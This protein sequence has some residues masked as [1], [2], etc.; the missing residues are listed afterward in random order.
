MTTLLTRVSLVWVPDRVNIWLRFGHP[1]VEYI[2]D[3]QRRVADF[4][5]G[6]L[7]CRIEWQAN[8]YGTTRWVLRVLQT[9]DAGE[10]VQVVTGVQP[11]ALVLLRVS[12]Q[13]R[14]MQVLGLIDD[15]EAQGLD[16][17]LTPPHYWRMA[18]NR[19]AANLLPPSYTPERQA[20]SRAV[21]IASEAAR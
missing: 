6:M 16:P 14:V 2:Q 10:A 1:V 15:M 5:P 21:L 11:G 20:A 7:L 9:A 3:S 18:H 8:R 12:S 17:T 19:L 4:A 13:Q